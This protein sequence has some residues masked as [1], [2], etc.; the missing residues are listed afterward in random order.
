MIGIT[1]APENLRRH[2]PRGAALMKQGLI[3]GVESSQS[4]VCYTYFIV[5]LILDGIDQNIIK[6]NISVNNFLLLEKVKCKKHLL[7]NDSYLTFFQ[8][9]P[10]HYYIHQ[11]A[12]GLV[13]E[14]D[15]HAILVLVEPKQAKDT[16]ALFQGPMNA[17]LV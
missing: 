14:D 7:H 11:G 8:F 2:I 1:L 16:H 6:L 15:A 4:K 13:F 10:F 9:D 12:F 5:S 3:L 17:D